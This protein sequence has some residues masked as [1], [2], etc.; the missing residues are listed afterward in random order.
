[1]ALAS[2]FVMVFTAVLMTGSAQA[3][4][5]AEVRTVQPGP[6]QSQA[7]TFRTTTTQATIARTTTTKAQTTQAQTTTAKPTTTQIRTTTARTT[8]TRTTAA[9]QPR[10]SIPA[11]TTTAAA[12]EQNAKTLEDLYGD[13]VGSTRGYEAI[14]AR[15]SGNTLTI[16]VYV[17]FKGAYDTV[18][19]GTIYANLA[20]QG[21]RLWAGTYKGSGYDF[22]PGMT[23][24]VQVVIHDV[25][26]GAGAR[27]G[28]HYFDFVCL[29]TCGRSF[30]F[31]GAG[32]YN[33]ELLGLYD[34][35]I[36]D[37]SYTNGSI[38]MYKGISGNYTAAQYIKVA[39]HEFG[40]VLGLG[41][42]YGKGVA[43][44]KECPQGRYYEQGDIMGTHG[45]VTPNNI[46]MML[47][48]YTTGWY[49]A[50]VNSG[51]PEVKSGAVKSY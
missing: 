48:A 16:D 3:A 49:Q 40:H 37:K 4:R 44:T 36:P 19:G 39:A 18:L 42:L 32:Y 28:Q 11:P 12:S 24:S 20:K 47:E 22:E 50:Y 21:F 35:A 14:Q 45:E 1:M 46:E 5:A 2:V 7:A 27:E 10:P 38:G 30:T 31:Y 33:R 17:N 25:Y 26:D 23:F 51:L 8:T 13:L 41:D 6:A 34:G 29:N 9:T 43:P 15:I